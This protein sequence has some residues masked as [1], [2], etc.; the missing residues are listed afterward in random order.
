M[1]II[2]WVRI[3]RF[4]RGLRAFV[5]F[6]DGFCGEKRGELMVFCGDLGG[7]FSDSKNVAF[8]KIFLWIFW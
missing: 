5:R 2:F 3:P 1:G 7:C 4:Y 6:L 8:L